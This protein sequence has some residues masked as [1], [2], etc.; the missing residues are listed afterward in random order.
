MGK[1]ISI[2]LG[3]LRKRRNRV[4]KRKQ[5]KIGKIGGD[6]RHPKQRDTR[7]HRTVTRW[8]HLPLCVAAAVVLGAQLRVVA[9]QAVLGGSQE[10]MAWI[11]R[12]EA[13]VQRRGVALQRQQLT[14]HRANIHRCQGQR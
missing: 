11:G 12:G 6:V 10:V 4:G 7:G 1:V 3:L 14:E 2:S 5:N 13:D 9:E 8:V